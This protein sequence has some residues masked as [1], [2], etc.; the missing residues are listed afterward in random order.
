MSAA[1]VLT[2]ET[3]REAWLEARRSVITA[4]DIAAILGLHPYRTPREVYLDKMGLLP[5]VPENEPM[6]W[7]TA[8]ESPIAQ[9]FA[10]SRGVVP[11]KAGFTR[12]PDYPHFGATPDFLIGKDALLEVKTAGINAGRNF[13][14]A[15]S[16]FVPDQY[17]CQVMWQMFVTGRKKGFLAVLIA[18]Q[19][20]REYDI[21]YSEEMVRR[22]VFHASKFWGE[23]IQAETPPPI[24][25]AEPDTE[26]LRSQHP[27]DDGSMIAASPEMEDIAAELGNL[28]E[29]QSNLDLEVEKRKN[30]LREFMGDAQVMT[31]IHGNFTWKTGETLGVDWKALTKEAP[32]LV[33]KHRTKPPVR[34]F[35]TPFKSQKA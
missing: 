20:Y 19:D 22:M 5:E 12:H 3:D 21:P 32:D 24:S 10:F 15:G 1:A 26:R 35:R 18:G 28:L 27:L 29:A 9:R 4:T 25:G 16:D 30:Q 23:Y 31:S 7:G 33:A 13:G 2:A 6:Y 11:E 14:E 17:L 34:T 8:L